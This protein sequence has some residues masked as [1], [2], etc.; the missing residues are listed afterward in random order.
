M[1]ETSRRLTRL[2]QKLLKYG[3]PLCVCAAILP[4]FALAGHVLR[5]FAA[6]PRGGPDLATL[7]LVGSELTL[8]TFLALMAVEVLHGSAAAFV[9]TLPGGPSMQLRYL[10]PALLLPRTLMA[11]GLGGGALVF[12]GPRVDG[13]LDAATLIAFGLAASVL[14]VDG[15]FA[16]ALLF[17]RAIAWLAA[18]LLP[19]GLGF[20]L[21]ANA[22][23]S[24]ADASWYAA[25]AE[26]FGMVQPMHWALWPVVSAPR[27]PSC[28][29][30]AGVAALVAAT[31]LALLALMRTTFLWPSRIQSDVTRRTAAAGAVA[32]DVRPRVTPRL[33]EPLWI[34]A[35]LAGWHGDALVPRV[36]AVVL[37][38]VAGLALHAAGIGPRERAEVISV[39]VGF[40]VLIVLICALAAVMRLGALLN[41]TFQAARLNR[42]ARAYPV[43]SLYPVSPW[44]VAAGHAGLLAGVT[45]FTALVIGPA[46]FALFPAVPA[47]DGLVWFPFAVAG[48][49]LA[50]GA[51]N[52]VESISRAANSAQARMRSPWV[53][54]G[55]LVL[56]AGIGVP[57]LC[58]VATVAPPLALLLGALLCLG[59]AGCF[60]RAALDLDRAQGY[61]VI[62]APQA[63]AHARLRR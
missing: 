61:D 8:F 63:A 26:W 43:W 11:L 56:T 21:I 34:V 5:E 37:L 47:A 30:L 36:L 41:A 51:S 23:V 33:P 18:L 13:A 39:S 24:P 54:F 29:L 31:R 42:W 25:R 1:S 35:R 40:I 16:L 17:G 38:G 57:A 15:A 55:R 19:V 12:G 10:E 45:G 22:H 20:I 59:F 52:L 32:R 48:I 60:V 7:M 9:R 62:E 2:Q 4:G 3:A 58:V 28:A 14:A 6:R 27:V 49:P 46:V 44:A 50:V 53:R